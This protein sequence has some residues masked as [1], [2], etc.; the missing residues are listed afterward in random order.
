M[1]ALALALPSDS[2]SDSDCA[3]AFDSN[4]CIPHLPSGPRPGYSLPPCV[5][6][7]FYSVSQLNHCRSRIQRR[8]L[9]GTAAALPQSVSNRYPSHLAR[10]STEQDNRLQE[11]ATGDCTRG[12]RLRGIRGD[13]FG[14]A[15]HWLCD[16]PRPTIDR[17]RRKRIP[18]RYIFTSA[19]DEHKRATTAILSAGHLRILST[20]SSPVCV[21]C[22]PTPST[23]PCCGCL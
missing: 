23:T 18:H 13:R 12:W 22:L 16:P 20:I 7:L 9:R 1:L 17:R 21:S 3:F 8:S 4:L 2:E 15:E 11:R 14:P 10:Y 5:V 6:P 19:E